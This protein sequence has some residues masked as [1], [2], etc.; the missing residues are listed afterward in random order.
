M[1]LGHG[2]DAILIYR[3]GDPVDFPVELDELPDT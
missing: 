3:E 2:D 1:W